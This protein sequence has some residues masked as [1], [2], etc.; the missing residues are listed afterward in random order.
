LNRDRLR[1]NEFFSWEGNNTPVLEPGPI[2]SWEENGVI[3]HEVLYTETKW[4]MWYVAFEKIYFA[5]ENL[6]DLL[7]YLR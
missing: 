2:G 5:E 4:M 7:D 1:I 3:D 6:L